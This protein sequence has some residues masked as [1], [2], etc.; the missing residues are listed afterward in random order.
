MSLSQ[1]YAGVSRLTQHAGTTAMSRSPANGK[2]TK[3]DT[4]TLRALG[5]RAISFCLGYLLKSQHFLRL[6]LTAGGNEARRSMSP[7]LTQKLQRTKRLQCHS[8]HGNGKTDGPSVTGRWQF[9]PKIQ[10]TRR[11]HH[12]RINLSERVAK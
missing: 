2:K 11:G 5:G 12:Q 9:E 1:R 8:L 7:A 4:G 6:L 3:T 10:A